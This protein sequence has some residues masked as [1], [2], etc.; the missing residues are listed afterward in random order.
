MLMSGLI[1][2]V[3]YC[4]NNLEMDPKL[5]IKELD[6]N[7]ELMAKHAKGLDE[8][9]FN[10]QESQVRAFFSFSFSQIFYLF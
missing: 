6:M 2:S 4:N 9:T 7:R 8:I 10:L 5:R 1:F 3:D